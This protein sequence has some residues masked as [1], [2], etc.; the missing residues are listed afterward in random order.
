MVELDFSQ[1]E[2]RRTT[3]YGT[4]AFPSIIGF[5]FTAMV[6]VGR[7]H[8]VFFPAL[9]REELPYYLLPR[10]KYFKQSKVIKLVY[11]VRIHRK[12]LNIF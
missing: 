12:E 4:L 8:C 9:I 10:Q 5:I 3:I 2:A 1:N 7:A 11:K 6:K